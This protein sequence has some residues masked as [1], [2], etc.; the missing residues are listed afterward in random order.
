MHVIATPKAI[1]FVLL[2]MV[3]A[4]L[5]AG[6]STEDS[7]D[8]ALPQGSIMEASREEDM[9]LDQS[10]QLESTWPDL[11]RRRRRGKAQKKKAPFWQ[12]A[13]KL[14]KKAV[15]GDRKVTMQAITS[16]VRRRRNGLEKK[17]PKRCRQE[18]QDRILDTKCVATE[19]TRSA[20]KKSLIFSTP[21]G[22]PTWRIMNQCYDKKGRI[23]GWNP[24]TGTVTKCGGGVL[25]TVSCPCAHSSG[26]KKG[27]KMTESEATLVI[28]GQLAPHRIVGRIFGKA[29]GNMKIALSTVLMLKCWRAHCMAAG[30]NEDDDDAAAVS[31]D[32]QLSDLLKDHNKQAASWNCA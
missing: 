12:K 11:F 9:E 7:P 22:V 4:I 17:C 31:V 23:W 24:E 6:L 32:T 1:I 16:M 20:I 27:K 3:P 14:L 30:S 5:G 18:C 19:K 28:L 29:A 8:M 26:K 21:N 2:L 25:G 15:L 10:V 13:Q